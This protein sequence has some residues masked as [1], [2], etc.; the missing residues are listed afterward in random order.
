MRKFVLTGPPGSGKTSIITALEQMGQNVL[1]EAAT[2]VILRFQA[3]G[4]AEPWKLKEFQLKI[5]ELQKLREGELDHKGTTFLDRCIFDSLHYEED[6]KTREIILTAAR[7]A[8]YERQVFFIEMMHSEY[9]KTKVCRQT[10]A[11]AQEDGRQIEKLYQ[12]YGFELIRIPL[13]SIEER[14]KAVLDYV[15]NYP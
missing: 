12:K 9:E 4:I 8:K 11:E 3:Q 5:V 1:K 14:A 10:Y 13:G 15:K 6:E 7:S 2:E